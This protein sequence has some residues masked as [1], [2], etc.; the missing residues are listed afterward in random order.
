MHYEGTLC[1]IESPKE[2]DI[3]LKKD[4]LFYLKCEKNGKQNYLEILSQ[5]DNNNRENISVEN[6]FLIGQHLNLDK[7]ELSKLLGKIKK[8]SPSEVL[9]FRPSKRNRI[10]SNFYEKYFQELN[11]Y[12][13]S[14]ISLKQF[15][16]GHFFNMYKTVVAKDI[17]TIPFNVIPTN[18]P[19]PIQEKKNN[20]KFSLDFIL[21][22]KRPNESSFDEDPCEEFDGLNKQKNKR[23]KRK[24]CANNNN[25]NKLIINNNIHNNFSINNNN[26]P[27]NYCNPHRIHTNK[28][29]NI[30]IRETITIGNDFQIPLS[31]STNSTYNIFSNSK[32]GEQLKDYIPVNDLHLMRY[33]FDPCFLNVMNVSIFHQKKGE[34]ILYHIENQIPNFQEISSDSKFLELSVKKNELFAIDLTIKFDIADKVVSLFNGGHNIV[35]IKSKSKISLQEIIKDA[36][37]KKIFK[38]M[39]IIIG[40][41]VL[42]VPI[43]V[44]IVDF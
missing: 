5:T 10:V 39:K 24:I 42:V 4:T 7:N 33:N 17:I 32:F 2:G 21:N 36:P 26:L 16:D 8:E 6:I 1:I 30:N 9:G 15:M 38:F 18:Y 34:S 43:L 11:S 22:K 23:G 40:N 37:Y 3:F 12:G 44:N 14:L 19:E 29:I 31:H 27:I 28:E 25:S 20:T 13:V 35:G 41:V